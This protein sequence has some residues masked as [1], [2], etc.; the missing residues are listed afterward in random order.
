MKRGDPFLVI[1]YKAYHEDKDRLREMKSQA[2]T[3]FQW[4]R[5]YYL[6]F[7]SDPAYESTE[8]R[9]SLL[10][11]FTASRPSVEEKAA[12]AKGLST[13]FAEYL[14]DNGY[15]IDDSPILYKQMIMQAFPPLL[16]E[17]DSEITV[18][19]MEQAAVN[20][21][22]L[23]NRYLDDHKISDA[24]RAFAGSVVSSQIIT[25]TDQCFFVSQETSFR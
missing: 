14:Q 3:D 24:T 6:D 7:L 4:L 23:L 15:W 18:E 22:R 13:W 9:Q 21:V 8:S 20:Y 12:M 17:N 11:Q 5:Q 16:P 1:P 25:K 2:K 10:G 19:N